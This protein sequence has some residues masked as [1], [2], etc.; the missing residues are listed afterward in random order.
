M[1]SLQKAAIKIELNMQQLK[2]LNTSKHATAEYLQRG[3][4]TFFVRVIHLNWI[5]LVMTPA[6]FLTS[7]AL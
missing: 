3:S 4:A 6:F 1:N 7:L 2:I 5:Q